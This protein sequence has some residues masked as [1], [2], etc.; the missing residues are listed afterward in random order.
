LATEAA[1]ALV[2]VAFEID[3]VDRVEIHCGPDNVRSQAIPRKLGFTHEA[4][5]RRRF[6][7][8]DDQLR[9][10]MIWSLFANSYAHSP[11][12]QAE[13]AAFD[14]LGRRIVVRK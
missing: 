14:A 2:Q 11:A 12:S 4:T 13:I 6:R 5:L 10:T 9:D 3:G 1:A 7:I 8:G